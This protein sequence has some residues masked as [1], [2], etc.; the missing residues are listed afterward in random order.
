MNILTDEFMSLEGDYPLAE[1]YAKRAVR[2]ANETLGSNSEVTG[3]VYYMLYEI[4][5][6]RHKIKEAEEALNKLISFSSFLFFWFLIFL[7]FVVT[8][9]IVL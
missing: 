8:F 3:F 7:T 1:D 5:Y 6:E 2:F 9:L 4:Y